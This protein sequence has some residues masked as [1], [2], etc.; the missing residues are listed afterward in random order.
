MTFKTALKATIASCALL[1][2]A[3]AAMADQVI[4]THH[5]HA[6]AA[7]IAPKF[8][9]IRRLQ[10]NIHSPDAKSSS[11]PP[12]WTFSYTYSGKTYNE[13]FI[14]TAVSGGA[15]TTVPVYIVPLKLTRGTTSEDPTACR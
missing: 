2:P 11:F 4:I 14:G 12:T 7:G 13:T 10:T 3:G 6:N 15:T 5:G 1:A 8:A 9:M